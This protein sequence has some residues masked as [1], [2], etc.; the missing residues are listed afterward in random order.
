VCIITI[1]RNTT[2]KQIQK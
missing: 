2:A 1:A